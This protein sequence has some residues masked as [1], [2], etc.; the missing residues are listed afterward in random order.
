MVETDVLAGV[1]LTGKRAIVTGANSGL[2]RETTGALAAAGA[3]V[4]LA[5]R[6][7]AAGE[8]AAAELAAA[9]AAGSLAVADLDLTD[10][11]SIAAFVD[12]WEEPLDILVNNAGVMAVPERTLTAQGWELQFATNHLG[13]FALA[14]GLHD[15]LAAAPEARIVSLTSRG[16]FRSPV[17]FDDLAFASR[18]YEPFVAYGQSKTANVLFAVEATRRWA[19]DGITANAAFPGVV[20][21]TGLA[22][23]VDP[24]VFR[25]K[26][27]ASTVP[28]KTPAEGAATILMVAA[29]PSLRGVGGRYFEDCAEAPVVEKVTPETPGGVAPHALDPAA[30]KRLWEVS[31]ELLAAV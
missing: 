15:H 13:H 28:P 23:F 29:S 18:P 19:A 6:D 5:V 30:A 3:R 9:T 26:L 25:Q 27:S 31:E 11:R 1:D 8:R 10:P 2:G 17:L 4:T 20:P 14:T 12:A 7:R 16:H 24:V 22:R 21:D